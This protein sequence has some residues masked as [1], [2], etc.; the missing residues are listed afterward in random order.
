V[1]GDRISRAAASRLVAPSAT[2]T[3][4]L[5]SVGVRPAHPAAAGSWPA[6]PAGAAAPSWPGSSRTSAPTS[7]SPSQTGLARADTSAPPARRITEAAGAGED[8]SRR[9]QSHSGARSAALVRPVAAVLACMVR[10][11]TEISGPFARRLARRKCSNSTRS[12]ADIPS[13]R[14]CSTSRPARRANGTIS[15]VSTCARAVSPTAPTVRPVAGSMIG[16]A[17]HISAARVSVKCSSPATRAGL[18]WCSAIPT[19]LVPMLSS[20]KWHPGASGMRSNAAR[21][22][23]SGTLRSMISACWSASTRLTPVPA[24]SSLSWS[25]TGLAACSRRPPS[26]SGW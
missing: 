21:R 23:R 9:A 26:T 13:I 19:A 7:T 18:C 22:A 2:M 5:C 4:T 20:P 11:L 3:A 24:R 1:C 25:A 17:E 12:A 14:R 10:S 15:D 8:S 16:A 6:P